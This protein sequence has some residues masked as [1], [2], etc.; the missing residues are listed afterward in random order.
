MAAQS[1]ELNG[2]GASGLKRLV[3][4]STKAVLEKCTNIRHGKRGRGKDER[5]NSIYD[6][7]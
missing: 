2:C 5:Y 1:N 3:H 4:H 7:E 6:M